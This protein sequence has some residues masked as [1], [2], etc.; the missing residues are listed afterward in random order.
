VFHVV[1]RFFPEYKN[2]E[3]ITI[4]HMLAQRSGIPALDAGLSTFNLKRN[5]PHTTTE[6]IEYFKDDKLL[7]EPGSNY[8]HGRTE[9]SLVG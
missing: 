2:G 9:D 4:H 3:Q 1:C 5:K 6:L 8:S 7:F